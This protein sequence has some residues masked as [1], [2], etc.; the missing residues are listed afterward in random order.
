MKRHYYNNHDYLYKPNFYF[1][2]LYDFLDGLQLIEGE[3]VGLLKSGF[4]EI[5]ESFPPNNFLKAK[6]D[7]EN[8]GSS[9]GLILQS[10]FSKSNS[11]FEV[12]QGGIFIGTLGKTF[13]PK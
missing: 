11:D 9:G 8:Q 7:A 2:S 5:S 1:I 4:L 10:E 6:P 3:T 13:E 12:C